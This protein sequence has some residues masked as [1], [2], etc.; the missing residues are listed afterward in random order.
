MSAPGGP[1]S[2]IDHNYISVADRLAFVDEKKDVL[3][4]AEDAIAPSAVNDTLKISN[5]SNVTI[6]NKT[7]V[8]YNEDCL[9][10]CR[11]HSSAFYNL[12]LDPRGRNGVTVKGASSNILLNVTLVAHGSEC[13]IELGQFDNYWYP[14]RPPT[15]DVT[16]K[17]RSTDGQP[18][19]VRLWDAELGEVNSFIPG[20]RI[21]R[22]PKYVWFPYFL[23]RYTQLRLENVVRRFRGLTPIRTK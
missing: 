17:A 14:G 23:F 9:D 15:R 18:V 8:N 1:S 13:D 5:S 4:P 7:I 16:I 3:D 11:V 22:V 19:V 12:V 2:F 6:G 20:A 21:V 10:L